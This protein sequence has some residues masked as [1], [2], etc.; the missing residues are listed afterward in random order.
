MK[1]ESS[2]DKVYAAIREAVLSGKLKTGQRLTEL[3]LAQDFNVSR[4]VIR[5]TLQRLAHNGLVV[6][7][8]YKG[9]HVVQL[10]PHEVDEIIS[11][12]AAL[13]TEAIRQ[14]KGR[15]TETDKRTLRRMAKKLDDLSRNQKLH[16]EI[17]F[18]ELDFKLHEKLWELSG[19]QT[20]IKILTQ[21]TAPLFAMGSIVRYS[22]LLDQEQDV[23]RRAKEHTLLVEKIC[24]GTIE[25][26][27]RAM[28]R[29]ITQNWKSIRDHFGEFL[30]AEEKSRRPPAR[31]TA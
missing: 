26:A 5:E 9:T 3:Q 19:N 4:V 30:E 6:Q 16:V 8:S 1:R 20:L 13:E 25:E 28:H 7:N 11:V 24:E 14:A 12:R 22:K 31:L 17:E 21:V 23:A 10:Q 27:T 29:H 15:L 18:R 2:S